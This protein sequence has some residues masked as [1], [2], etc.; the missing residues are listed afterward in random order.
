MN[1]QIANTRRAYG[2]EIECIVPSA[3][4]DTMIASAAVEQGVDVRSERYNHSTRGHWKIIWDSSISARSGFRGIEIVSPKLYGTEGL[5]EI[6]IVCKVLQDLGA[7]VNT[8]CGL[9]VHHDA[10]DFGSKHFTNIKQIY[11]T[12][13]PM[14][15]AIMPASRRGNFNTYCRSVVGVDDSAF[16]YTRYYKLNV[17]SYTR[18]GSLEFRHH[19][20]TLNAVKIIAWVHLTQ[21]IMERAKKGKMNTA[22]KNNQYFFFGLHIDNRHVA[23]ELRP[24]YKDVRNYYAKR[25]RQLAAA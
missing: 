20:G 4:Q 2:I 3:I 8:S 11:R 22:M 21:A 14:L 9:H 10:S 6:E 1:N 25:V 19:A 23:A 5:K 16:E 24:L 7:I 13:E 15:D 12:A 17:T 18:H